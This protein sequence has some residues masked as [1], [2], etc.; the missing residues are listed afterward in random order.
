[1]PS[2]F[3]ATLPLKPKLTTSQTSFRKDEMANSR[4]QQTYYC[5]NCGSETARDDL[6][7]KKAVFT[8]MGAKAKTHKSRVVDQLCPPCL[9][10]DPDWK[11]EAFS[12][13][14]F[15]V[16]PPQF[17]EEGEVWEVKPPESLGGV[18]EAR[19]HPTPE[20][21]DPQQ[22]TLPGFEAVS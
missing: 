14:E 5:T 1:M 3:L 6:T 16:L 8:E 7:V 11:R 21:V 10:L 13:P 12:E 20:P 18:A 22:P 17:R 15:K 19:H 2:V 4:F 9:T